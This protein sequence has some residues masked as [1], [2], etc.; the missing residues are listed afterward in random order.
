MKNF[1]EHFFGI[2]IGVFICLGGCS[3]VFGNNLVVQGGLTSLFWSI[4]LF[5]FGYITI[6]KNERELYEFDVQSK[7]ILVDIGTRGVESDYFGVY[8]LAMIN[9]LRAK[10]VKKL[11]NQVIG[12]FSIAVILLICAFIFIFG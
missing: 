11:H 3:V 2:I 5:V 1:K 12:V 8:D 7:S 6:G 4:A 9:K 10:Y